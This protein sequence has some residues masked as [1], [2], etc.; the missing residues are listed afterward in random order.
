MHKKSS[1][2][3]GGPGQVNFSEDVDFQ[4]AS[5]PSGMEV[6]S[7]RYQGRW[8]RYWRV[9]YVFFL[10][11]PGAGTFILGLAASLPPEVMLSATSR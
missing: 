2:T 11:R 10:L 4:P 7:S 8:W 6:E 9:Q 1:M 5:S 3:V